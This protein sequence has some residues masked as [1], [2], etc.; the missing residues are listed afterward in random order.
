MQNGGVDE[1]TAAACSA[2]KSL[3]CAGK[4]RMLLDI[5]VA[6]IEAERYGPDVERYLDVYLRTPDIAQEDLRKAL[7]IRANARKAAGEMLLAKA[8]QGA[9]TSVAISCCTAAV[10][11]YAFIHHLHEP[12]WRRAPAEV[13][14]HIARFIPRYHLRTWL[15]VSS[16]Y[17]D[18]AARRIFH[19]LDLYFGG[20]DQES[21]NRGLDVLDRVKADATF[22]ARVRTLRLHWAYEEG[23]MFD[24]I[25]RL[26]RA[27]L[28]AFAALR[29]FEWIGYPEM[30]VEMVRTLLSSHPRLQG[31]GL[32]G[33]H[34]DAVGVS[35]L[36]NLHR[37]CLRAE[38]DDGFA[39]MGEVRSVLDHNAGTLRHLT[40]GAHLQRPHSWDGAFQSGTIR[41]LTHLDLV[42]T[43]I[44][45]AVLARIAHAGALRSLTLH[46]TFEEPEAAR[47]V[48]AADY[49]VEEEGGR[50]RHAMLPLLEA[51]RFVMV[52]MDDQRGLYEA[53]SQFVRMRPALRRLDL[54]GCPWERVQGVLGGLT[55][56]RVLRVKFDRLDREIVDALVDAIPENMVALHVA[57]TS[58]SPLHLYATAFRAFP[59]LSMLHLRSHS[60][61]RPQ[62]TLMSDKEHTR[63]TEEW[64]ANARSV[65]AALPLLDFVGWHGEHYIVCGSAGTGGG[66]SDDRK[67]KE[68][69][70]H[71]ELKEL[72]SRRRLDCGKGVDLGSED[73]AW[74]ERKDV[75][76]DYEMAGLES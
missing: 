1:L 72:P 59:S 62:P 10:H 13:W 57:C 31:L 75:P 51:F 70:M 45:H 18:I 66:C 7:R 40:L 61:A 52:G 37:F 39:D 54:G 21:V 55:G 34:F 74:M 58:A 48:F 19:T 12:A 69:G 8:Q 46:G 24:L 41:S 73:A 27:A 43:R 14:E 56:L 5:C 36:R 60:A 20:D 28:P 4:A 32:I 33:W 76:M 9:K 65:A 17:H 63:Q 11:G 68:D 30:R 29:E 26:F 67:E 71:V 64:L 50:A 38:D 15:S 35:G 6:L 42:D 2:V 23:D 16:F 22:A 49:L 53:V 47:A 25:L 44:S 3:T